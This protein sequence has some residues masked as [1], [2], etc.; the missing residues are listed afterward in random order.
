VLAERVEALGHVHGA[1]AAGVLVAPRDRPVERPVDL[2]R[3]VVV[4]EAL[5]LD[6]VLGREHALVERRGAAV[7]E[8]RPRGVVRLAA[9]GAHAGH[10]A[11]AREDLGHLGVADDLPALGLQAPGER[12]RQPA[13]AT[14]CDRPAERLPDPAQHPAVER[15]AGA[16]GRDV[17]VQGVAGQQPG[18][19]VAVELLLDVPAQRQDPE[20][21]EVED[22]LRRAERAQHPHGRP[23]RR[24]GLHQGPDEARL[25]LEPRRSSGAARRRRPRPRRIRRTRR[26]G[27]RRATAWRRS[28]PTPDGRRPLRRGATRGRSPRARGAAGAARQCPAG[29][30]R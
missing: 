26:C 28:R 21:G 13:G 5:E 7:G 11:A 30:R 10:A 22:G 24:E 15:A 3:A 1:G 6:A 4:V 17:G 29:R 9:G 16:V 19:A 12:L 27:R 25:D 2:E 23:D 14:G 18:G 20:A 8:H